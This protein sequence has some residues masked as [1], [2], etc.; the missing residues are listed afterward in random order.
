MGDLQQSAS[1]SRHQ[2]PDL[3]GRHVRS[4]RRRRHGPH[5]LSV[6]SGICCLVICLSLIILIGQEEDSVCIKFGRLTGAAASES[7]LR[8]T[9]ELIFMK[10]GLTAENELL[11]RKQTVVLLLCFFMSSGHRNCLLC[12]SCRSLFLKCHWDTIYKCML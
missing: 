10:R 4:Q 11:M 3:R 5:R 6:T 12:Q 7:G 8:A 1:V 9:A 2:L